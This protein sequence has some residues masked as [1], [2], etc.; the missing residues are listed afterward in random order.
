MSLILG[1]AIGAIGSIYTGITSMKAADEVA[2]DMRYQGNILYRESLRT[3]AI[4]DEQGRKFAAEQS[5]QYIGSGVQIAGSALVTL[6]Q[7]R[8]YAS[9]EAAAV[10]SKGAAERNLAYKG[11]QRKVDAGRASMISGIIGGVSKFAKVGVR[12][13]TDSPVKETD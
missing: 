11:A 2:F 3:A 7:T 9:T 13:K 1:A 6:D 8:K 5:L 4:I 12:G 10:R